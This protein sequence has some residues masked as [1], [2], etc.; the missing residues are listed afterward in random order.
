MAP[1]STDRGT[2]GGDQP[3]VQ[4]GVGASSWVWTPH[5]EQAGNQERGRARQRGADG[6]L[7]AGEATTATKQLNDQACNQ[8]YDSEQQRGA[9]GE[10][11]GGEAAA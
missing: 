5:A 4:E 9:K 8:E 3:N 11:R 7:R 10:R 1:F 2:G 6:A